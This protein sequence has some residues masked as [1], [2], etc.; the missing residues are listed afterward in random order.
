M[1][2]RHTE[3]HNIS[4]IGWLRAAVLEANERQEFIDRPEEELGI[5]KDEYKKGHDMIRI[6]L[7]LLLFLGAAGTVSAEPLIMSAPEA[8]NAVASNEMLGSFA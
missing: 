1:I 5:T 2:T 3:H 6:F 8:A 7:L 4:R